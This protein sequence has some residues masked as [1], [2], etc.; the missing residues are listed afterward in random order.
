MT[1]TPAPAPAP[2]AQPMMY[3]E[4]TYVG[5]I[6]ISPEGHPYLKVPQGKG[7]MTYRLVNRD[8]WKMSFDYAYKG[9]IRVRGWMNDKHVIRYSNITR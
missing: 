8:L 1:T 7:E 5:Y 6:E 9:T 3:T 2:V 4:T